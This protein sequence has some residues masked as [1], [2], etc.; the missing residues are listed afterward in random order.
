MKENRAD[1]AGPGTYLFH[2]MIIRILSA[3]KIKAQDTSLS[4][5]N[6]HDNAWTTKVVRAKPELLQPKLTPII[7]LINFINKEM[8]ID[9]TKPT[10]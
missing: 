8:E 7:C 5:M 3:E 9:R 10:F 2:Y 1:H 4:S 6:L